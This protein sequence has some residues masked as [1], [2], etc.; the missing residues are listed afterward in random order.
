MNA[1][2]NRGFIL[3]I[4]D[5]AEIRYSLNR[6]LSA[7]HYR[8]VTAASGEEGLRL[9]QRE[10]PQ[11]VFLDNR[12]EGVSGLETLQH[13]NS[14]V[15]DA[16]VI[17]MT[18]YGATQTAIEAMKFGAFE[19]I[20]K[21]FDIKKVTGLAEKAM[22]DFKEHSDYS[23]E[24]RHSACEDED[25]QEGLV[26]SSRLMQE[27]FKSIGKVAATDVT[28]L[29]TGESGTGKELVAR[30]LWRHSLRN[31]GHYL[32]VNCTAIPENL[33]ESELFGYEK[34]AFT[35]ADKLHKGKFEQCDGGT[36]FLDEIGDMSLATQSKILRTLQ[37]GEVQRVGGTK[38]TRVDV[39]LLAATHRNLEQM[40]AEGSFREDLYY[41]LNV[42]RIALP[43][44]RERPEDIPQIVEFLLRRL[45]RSGKGK[46]RRISREV[47]DIL[48]KYRWPGNVRELEN[49]LQRSALT[50]RGQTILAGDLPAEIR[51]MGEPGINHPEATAD[52]RIEETSQPQPIHEVEADS[53]GGGLA[54]NTLS[55]ALD[56]AY[57][58]IRKERDHSILH[59]LEREIIQRALRETGGNQVRT[60]VLL[61]ISRVTLRKRIKESGLFS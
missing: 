35:G 50:A 29:I 13:L 21:P 53:G 11:V 16:K 49:V 5:D 19:Y 26:G 3:V 61:G 51:G 4:D 31:A 38:T 57:K 48:R 40:V 27:V 15:P 6:V 24:S 12:M 39:R 56:V 41:R 14:V 32:S 45:V 30:S 18:A 2:F 44:L 37:E 33:I 7:H 10:N 23:E 55:D 52:T 54:G 59:L 17:L 1:D 60:A 22:R 9:A 25:I 8:V 36:L 46:T 42:M 58:E 43:P 34:G 20:L 28:V 47:M